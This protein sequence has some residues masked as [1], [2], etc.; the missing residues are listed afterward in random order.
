[1]ECARKSGRVPEPD[2]RRAVREDFKQRQ[3]RCARSSTERI[4]ASVGGTRDTVAPA[5]GKTKN[6]STG[7][8]LDQETAPD[9]TA[10]TTT[11][12]KEKSSAA[13]GA[14]RT[15]EKTRT[16]KLLARANPMRRRLDLSRLRPRDKQLADSS[17]PKITQH[18]R[19]SKHDFSITTNKIYN[20][21]M[22][23]PLNLSI[24]RSSSTTESLNRSVIEY[25]TYV[26]ISGPL[27]QVSYFC[28]DPHRCTSYHTCHLHTTRQANTIL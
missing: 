3:N 17:T 23:V 16:G 27:H 19:D 9:L 7:K 6:S 18:N 26:I 21:S 11:E 20:W 5:R 13:T 1:M 15:R 4:R 24:V 14:T 22:E 28:H 12:S 8:L 10:E 25:L 2:T